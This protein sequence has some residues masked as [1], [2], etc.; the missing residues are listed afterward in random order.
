MIHQYQLAVHHNSLAIFD[1]EVK[2]A[3][4]FFA[5]KFSCGTS[6]MAE[7]E[8]IIQ[9]A[10]TDNRARPTSTSMTNYTSKT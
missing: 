5:Q 10:F 3:Q 7:D 8:I 6:V 2:E 1:I 4:L 9:G